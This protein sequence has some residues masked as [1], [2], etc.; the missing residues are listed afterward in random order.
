MRYL[1]FFASVDR[2]V[3]LYK[4][5]KNQRAKKHPSFFKRQRITLNSEKADPDDLGKITDGLKSKS[6][7]ITEDGPHLLFEKGRLSR[8]G[9]YIN[10]TGLI[11]VL[12]GSM[13]RFF[14]M[15]IDEV[16]YIPEGE[17]VEVPTTDNKYYIKTK[18]SL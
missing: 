18:N 3:L 9:P 1:L 2:G 4:S 17:T 13:L 5:L 14:G 8:W 6:Y 15:Y 16:L 11:I 7:K 10:H 12:I